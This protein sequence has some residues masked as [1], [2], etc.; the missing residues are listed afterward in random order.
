LQRFLVIWTM[1]FLQNSPS[2]AHRSDKLT[3]KNSTFF[4]PPGSVRSPSRIKLGWCNQMILTFTDS[5]AESV[6]ASVWCPSIC[7]SQFRRASNSQGPAST[8]PTY[9]LALLS[10]SRYICFCRLFRYHVESTHIG[11]NRRSSPA[12]Y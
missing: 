2:R 10:K 6:N 3:N 5:L 9:V 8:Q 1:M 11:M 7:L 12:A 4:A